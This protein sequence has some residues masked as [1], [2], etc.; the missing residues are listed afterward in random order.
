MKQSA[1]T[2][3]SGTG[4]KIAQKGSPKLKGIRDQ[5]NK[6]G[7]NQKLSESSDVYDQKG[8]IQ[9]PNQ[10][11]KGSTSLPKLP[12]PSSVPLPKPPL[13]SLAPKPE[14]GNDKKL[15]EQIE[16]KQK[17][18]QLYKTMKKERAIHQK[19]QRKPAIYFIS[20]LEVFGGQSDGM[21]SL[22]DNIKGAK[23]FSWSQKEDMLEGIQNTDGRYPVI[24]VGHGLGADTAVEIAQE[25]NQLE[26][27]YRPVKLLMTIDSVGFD[28]DI[29]DQNVEKN[30]HF[31]SD[32]V[33]LFNDGPNVARDRARTEVINI[34][35]ESN[36]AELD[37]DPNIQFE[38]VQHLQGTLDKVKLKG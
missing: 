18:R 4:Q 29:I 7:T 23:H 37:V 3:A 22:A 30:V 2:E 38:A 8:K 24:L 32:R 35:S 36:Y 16:Q 31:F 10:S 9:T 13:T 26:H 33:G 11:T 14:E 25:L 17:M 5:F 27:Q 15:K 20:G 12:L 1:V 21:K 19:L 34:L 6:I 28:N